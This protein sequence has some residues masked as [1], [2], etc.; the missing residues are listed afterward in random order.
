MPR[1]YVKKMGREG[2]RNYSAVYLENAVREV[3][4]GKLSI[5]KASECYGVPYTTLNEWVKGKRKN[6]Y[7]GQPVLNSKD[8]ECLVHGLIK[9]GE[10]GFPLKRHDVRNVVQGYLN[11]S[12]RVEKRFKNNK[13][14]RDWF[15]GFIK[16]NQELTERLV[17][18]IKRS[19]AGISEEVIHDYF[20]NLEVY[21]AD[22]PPSNIINFDETNFTD[23]PGQSKALVKRG[24]KHAEKI[25]D[26]SKTSVSVM[27]AATAEGVVLP[28]YVV[29]KAK[30]LYPTWIEN[31]IPGSG[32]NRNTSGWFDLEIFEDWFEKILLPFARKL[33]GRKVLIGDNLSSHLSLHVIQLCEENEID[34]ILLA[35]NTTHICQPLDVAFF[36]PLKGA[37]RKCLEEWKMKNRGVLPKCEFPKMLKKTFE[38]VGV[39]LTSNIVAGFAACGIVPLNRE[40]VLK[41]LPKSPREN[42]GLERRWS[43]TLV[44]H[45]KELRKETTGS[46]EKR[47][48]QK[49]LNVAAGKGIVVRDLV[50]SGDDMHSRS[51]NEN[52]LHSDS[53][54]FVEDDTGRSSVIDYGGTTE[55]GENCSS[56]KSGEFVLVSFPT[57]SRNRHFI[58]QIIQMAES[59]AEVSYLRK[60]GSKQVHFVFPDVPDVDKTPLTQIVTKV[61]PKGIGRGRYIFPDIDISKIE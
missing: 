52:Q 44:D 51:S 37:W 50:E 43:D 40:A 54:L 46:T 5:R 28:P 41:K 9:C 11:R 36:H 58:G 49:R 26:S 39:H 17:Q 16:R 34:F 14:G 25:M 48:R 2:K 42:E 57:G 13:P 6:S 8:E 18:N 29:Y 3:K 45:L 32:Y 59:D 30:Y 56:Y 4:K 27:I 55:E 7:G 15:L 24:V 20:D 22:M 1:T 23:D 53:E 61:K 12:G 31:G 47:P 60:R 33:N 10:W 19:R 21:V 38:E 35:P